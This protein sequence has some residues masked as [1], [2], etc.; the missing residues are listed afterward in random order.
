MRTACA[1]GWPRVLAICPGREPA[2]KIIATALT[3]RIARTIQAKMSRVGISVSSRGLEPVRNRD[4]TPVAVQPIGVAD[5]VQPFQHDG[6]AALQELRRP[7]EGGAESER[8]AHERPQ[9][10]AVAA[11]AVD[12]LVPVALYAQGE[13]G[14]QELVGH[15]IQMELVAASVVGRRV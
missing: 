4:L 3:T 1:Q 15:E 11:V 9:H 6:G 5:V 7:Q 14:R 12:L 2:M 10:R 13:G 8:F